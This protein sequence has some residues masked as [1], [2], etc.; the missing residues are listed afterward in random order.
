[1]WIMFAE[2]GT[3][4]APREAQQGCTTPGLE[5]I[6]AGVSPT[7]PPPRERRPPPH[8]QH[9]APSAPPSMIYP[10]LQEQRSTE[11]TMACAEE[12][13]TSHERPQKNHG[14]VRTQL[15]RAR[16]GVRREK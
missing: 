10:L 6:D 12:Q 7:A 11:K 1:M 8:P 2:M 14:E 9:Q 4:T 3:R 15:R 13:G 5:I 16:Q